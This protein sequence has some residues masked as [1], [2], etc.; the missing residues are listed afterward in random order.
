MVA[1]I[2]DYIKQPRTICLAVV[3]AT[4]DVADQSIL[5]W[6]RK[7][8]PKGER[9]LGVITKPDL[10]PQGSDSE[11]KIL[12]LARNDVLLKLGWHVV[13]NGSFEESGLSFAD[14]KTAEMTFFRTSNFCTLPKDID[15]LRE[16]LSQVLFEH[17]RNELPRLGE[18]LEKALQAAKEELGQ[19]GKSRSTPVECRIY[20]GQLN[21]QCY[22]I[23]RAAINGNYEHPYFKIGENMIDKT[24]SHQSP[25]AIAR[26]RA[27][28][29]HI[30]FSFSKMFRNQGHKYDI[31]GYEH[32]GA[33]EDEE[34]DEDYDAKLDE[35]YDE[36]L[37]EDY[38]DEMHEDSD[39]E[40]DD[41]SE[42]D[43][44]L[45]A[46]PS[47]MLT[48]IDALDW[49]KQ[50]L[51]RN[52]DKELIGN[53]NPLVIGDLFWEQ[54]EGWKNLAREHIELI[55]E[56]CQ[57]FLEKLLEATAPRDVKQRIW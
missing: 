39:E 8:D 7:F 11:A 57:N 26:L 12:E 34:L 20:L 21:M 49:V 45:E 31:S 43:K 50:A 51:I 27:L 41:G 5:Q 54:S 24:V 15:A 23:C 16:R 44:D 6:V 19:M 4:N 28:I 29:Q 30:N 33:G 9:T 36:E 47:G 52:R 10:L 25:I 14:R 18:E 35:D 17:V 1:E 46:T 2:T 13:K 40:T 42:L 38:K 53:Y 37:D 22:D 48:K 55:S 3:S 56:V 32:M